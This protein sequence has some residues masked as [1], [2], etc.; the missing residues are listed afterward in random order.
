MFFLGRCLRSGAGDVAFVD[1]LALDSIEGRPS[2]DERLHD[3]FL[4]VF[5]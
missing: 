3:L 1:H 2:P 4:D 5:F